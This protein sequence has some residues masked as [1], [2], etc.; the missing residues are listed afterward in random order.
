M[1]FTAL[2]IA[3]CRGAASAMLEIVRLAKAEQLDFSG[4]W[5]KPFAPSSF[6][7]LV[8][9][10]GAPSSVLAPTSHGIPWSFYMILRSRTV[11]SRS[12]NVLQNMI[13][14]DYRLYL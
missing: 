6:L 4:E 1:G 3:S 12:S 8:A 11:H 7:F 2:E 9:M 13:I 10:P 14:D 5:D